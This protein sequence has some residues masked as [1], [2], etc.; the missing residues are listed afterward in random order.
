MNRF[1]GSLPIRC[2]ECHAV[3]NQVI[4]F[5][6]LKNKKQSICPYCGTLIEVNYNIKIKRVKL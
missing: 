1:N 6:V 4:D 2:P 5:M 3:Y